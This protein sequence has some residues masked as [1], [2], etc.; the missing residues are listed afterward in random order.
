[1]SFDIVQKSNQLSG[2]VEISEHENRSAPSP[3]KVVDDF[4]FEKATEL[5]RE[6]FVIEKLDK[7]RRHVEEQRVADALAEFER[8]EVD[9]H[10][11][12]KFNCFGTTAS[13]DISTEPVFETP[14]SKSS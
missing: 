7:D 8:D 14:T 4:D 13:V 6:K 3:L 11:R 1:M 5:A 2:L 10:V 9:W 12:G